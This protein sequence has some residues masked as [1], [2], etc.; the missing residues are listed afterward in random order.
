[1]ETRD[2]LP[3]RATTYPPGPNLNLLSGWLALPFRRNPLGYL[4]RLA[5]NYGDVSCFRI[6]GRFVYLINHPDLIRAILSA[7]RG[8]FARLRFLRQLVV[9][10]FEDLSSVPERL[11]SLPDISD[12][13]VE[14]AQHTVRV[15]ANWQEG[16]SMEVFD[17]IT[18]L[19]REILGAAGV[20]MIVSTLGWSFLLLAHNPGEQELLQA[21]FKAVLSSRLPTLEDLEKLVLTRRALSETMRLYPPVWLICRKVMRD[22]PLDMYLLPR[23]STVLISPWVMHHDARYFPNP[24]R[25]EPSRWN[26]EAQGS[27]PHFTYLPFG[28][29]QVEGGEELPW[30]ILSLILTTLAREWRF[31]IPDSRPVV[32]KTDDLLRPKRKIIVTVEHR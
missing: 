4:A 25:F 21:E 27:L 1:M 2:N 10:P 15:A 20:E 7:D 6:D 12:R 26:R 5:S 8:D 16:Q 3:V 14:I 28:Y 11:Y 31:G 30:T 19:C 24:F 18:C 13:L 9:F 17:E 29:A 32:L 22:Y 23:G